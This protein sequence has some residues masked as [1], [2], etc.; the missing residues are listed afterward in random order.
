MA[1]QLLGPVVAVAA[2]GVGTVLV[3]ILVASFWPEMRKLGTL[4]EVKEAVAQSIPPNK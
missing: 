1:A 3:V 4:I 2:G